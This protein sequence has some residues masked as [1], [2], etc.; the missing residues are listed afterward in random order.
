MKKIPFVEIFLLL[1]AFV[2]Y[3][4]IRGGRAS[5]PNLLAYMAVICAGCFLYMAAA[6]L[7]KNSYQ[8]IVGRLV[9]NPY[10]AGLEKM[11][12]QISV[13]AYCSSTK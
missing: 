4:I 7:S 10:F 11:G 8:S 2:G 9:S 13:A 12:V 1:A 6:I 5:D 3:F